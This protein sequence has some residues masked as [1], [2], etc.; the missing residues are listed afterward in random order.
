MR[1]TLREYVSLY[2]TSRPGISPGAVEQIAVA[3][4][5]LDRWHGCPV[6]LKDLTADL[7]LRFLGDYSRNHAASTA[8]A[9]IRVLLRLWKHAHQERYLRRPAPQIPRV[10]EAEHLPEAWF[11]EELTRLVWAAGR[12]RGTI[13][14]IPRRH[15]WKSLLLSA[16]WTSCRISALRLARSEDCDLGKGWLLIRA[17]T[18]KTS[19]E[20]RYRLAPQAIGAI[21]LVYDPQRELIWPWPYCARTL[22]THFRQICESAGLKPTKR[23]M[24]LFQRIRRTSISYAARED[25]ELARRLAGHSSLE[26]TRR[27]YIDERIA[28]V[29]SVVNVLPELDI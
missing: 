11:A 22:Y 9:K 20:Q 4:H 15:W 14:G 5:V 26:I 24:G 25:L 28:Q 3:V 12:V 23:G 19:K 13:L 17:E 7:L 27:H 18:Q 2:A 1:V 29:P 16:Y 6:R 8:N 21:R 10:P